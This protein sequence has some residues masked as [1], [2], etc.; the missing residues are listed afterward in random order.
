MQIQTPRPAGRVRRKFSRG[1]TLTELLISIVIIVVLAAIS[2]PI[3]LKMKRKG[4]AAQCVS[5]LRQLAVAVQGEASELGYFPPVINQSETDSGTVNNAITFQNL[6]QHLTCTS[7][8]SAKY[9]GLDSRGR[10]IG[11]YGANPMVMGRTMDGVPPPVRVAEVRRPAEV[12]MM[13]DGAQFGE[14][15]PR[16]LGFNARWW[17]SKDGNPGDKNKELTEA[18]IPAS[19]FWDPGVSTLPLRHDGTANVVFC[20]GHVE[21]ITKIGDLKERNFYINY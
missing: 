17:G 14:P 18:D 6:T 13:S 11:A 2:F 8:P 20:D 12:M 10:H 1:F 3:G 16:P 5:N 4:Q 19:G 15:Y 21:T 9:T 7:C